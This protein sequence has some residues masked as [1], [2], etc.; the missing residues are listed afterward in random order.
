[1]D[2]GAFGSGTRGFVRLCFATDESTLKE[3]AVRIRRYAESLAQ[4]GVMH[5]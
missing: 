1:L 5:G 2:G 4:R 3:A